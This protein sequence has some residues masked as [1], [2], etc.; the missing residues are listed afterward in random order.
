MTAI[1]AAANGDEQRLM[2][3]RDCS[4]KAAGGYSIR[5]R[6]Q[7]IGY[8]SLGGNLIERRLSELLTGSKR[9]TAVHRSPVLDQ[10]QCR[11]NGRSL[12]DK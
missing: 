7:W 12:P 2:A 1:P 8:R 5:Q 4:A 9:H 6:L 10:H 3:Y 11:E